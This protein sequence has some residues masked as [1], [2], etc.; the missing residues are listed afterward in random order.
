MNNELIIFF[1]WQTSSRTDSLDNK[2]FILSCIQKA[3]NDVAGKGYLK[4]VT[5]KVLQGTGGEPGTPK[6]I[7]T[8]LK[9]NDKCH[10]W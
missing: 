7:E 6:M 3:A 2:A 4:E 9:R 1:S 8:C 5:F 10:I